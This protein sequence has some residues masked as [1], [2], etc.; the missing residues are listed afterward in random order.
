MI[1]FSVWLSVFVS[2]VPRGGGAAGYFD[3]RTPPGPHPDSVRHPD[4]TG[5][6]PVSCRARGG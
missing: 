3:L 5:C 4:G 1:Y 6:Q 2:G